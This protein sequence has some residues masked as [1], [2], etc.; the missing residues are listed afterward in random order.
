MDFEDFKLYITKH[1]MEY[2]PE[3]YQGA[4]IS[5]IK[6]VKNND[7]IW[8]GLQIAKKDTQMVPVLYINRAYQAY[9][10]GR[11]LDDV[12]SELADN[13]QETFQMEKEFNSDMPLKTIGEYDKVKDNIMCRLVN[14]AANEKLLQDKPFT[15]VEDL[16]VTYHIRIKSS[17][18]GIGSV[19]ITQDMMKLY[20]VDTAAL[21]EQAMSNMEKLSPTVIRPLND[22]MIDLVLPEFMQ[23]HGLSE[24]EA[25]DNLKTA[26]LENVSEDAPEIFCVTNACGINGAACIVSAE[27]QQKVAEKTGGDYYV[28]PSSIHEVFAV[29]KGEDISPDALREMV[30][31][32][33]GDVVS[34]GERL[35]GNVYEYN[36]KDRVFRIA[37]TA[38][39]IGPVSKMPEPEVQKCSVKLH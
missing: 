14:R 7:I 16:A 21:H 6:N 22:L 19:A 32:V 18:G 1:I 4:E 39:Q 29:P 17:E 10:E 25:R 26:M 23:E 36:A 33:N 27:V 8:E 11:N 9:Q 34:E 12:V 28:L 3:E 31:S 37:D 38:Q 13:Y 15:P 35:S 30:E 5:F 2:L 24:T 20:G